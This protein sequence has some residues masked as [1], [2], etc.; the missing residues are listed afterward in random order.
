M[1]LLHQGVVEPLHQGGVELLHK[2]VG[3]VEL[4]HD[5]EGVEPLEY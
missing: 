4:L 5:L 2:G 1:E 3:A